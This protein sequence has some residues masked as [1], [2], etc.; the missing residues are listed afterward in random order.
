M[1]SAIKIPRIAGDYV[2]VYK[3]TGDVFPGPDTEELKTGQ[4]YEEWVPN[5]HTFVRDDAGRWH[6]FGITHPLTSPEN[7]HDGECQAFHIIAPKGNLKDSLRKG[8]WQDQPKVLPPSERPDEIPLLYAPYIIRKDGLYQMIYS[9]QPL[10]MAVSKDLYE[11]KP[12][13]VI[14]GA[15]VGRDPNLLFHDGIYYLTVCGYHQ[16]EV[17]TS[18]NLKNWETHPPILKMDQVDPESPSLIRYNDTFYLF[19]CGWNGIW[20]Q[21]E[22]QGAYQHVTYVY[23][24]DNPLEF[25]QDKIITTIDAHAPEI[26]QDEDGD[27]YISSVEWPYCGVSLA[28][29]VWE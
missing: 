16:I 6:A 5:D 22:V 29:L 3:P 7:V 10:R 13:G 12:K 1:T 17:A 9:P 21:K 27:W 15:P 2:H 24:S 11:W 14:P 26:F 4:Y 25:T 20:D 19:V 28:R 18:T 8:S 23:Q